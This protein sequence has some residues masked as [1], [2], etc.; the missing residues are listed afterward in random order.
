MAPLVLALLLGCGPGV[1]N[2]INAA[3]TFILSV[4]HA[5]A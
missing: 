2:P 1:Y 4:E 3:G 5:G